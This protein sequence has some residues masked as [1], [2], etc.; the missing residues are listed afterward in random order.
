MKQRHRQNK[1][2]SN[3]QGPPQIKHFDIVSYIR[4]ARTEVPW[5]FKY[6]HKT[7]TSSRNLGFLHNINDQP[8]Q[9]RTMIAALA[10]FAALGAMV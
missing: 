9:H 6:K 4:S 7:E 2:H 8:S 1:Q 5:I 10:V 3:D